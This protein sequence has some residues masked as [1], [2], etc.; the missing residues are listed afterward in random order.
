MFHLMGKCVLM[1]GLTA[2]GVQN[3][4]ALNRRTA[5]LQGFLTAL[6]QIERE[7]AF[8]LLPLEALF[9]RLKKTTHGTVQDFFVCC[10]AAFENRQEERCRE[11]WNQSLQQTQ[12]PLKEEDLEMLQQV[13]VVLGQYDSDSQRKAL[14]NLQDRLREV[15]AESKEEAGRMGKVYGTLGVTLGLFCMILL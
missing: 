4:V 12:L 5:C 6:E 8:S 3:A 15:V 14:Q 2:F 9:N 1:L 13:G 7:L 11:I 10:G